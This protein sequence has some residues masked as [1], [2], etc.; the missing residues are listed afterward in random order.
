M[1]RLLYNIMLAL[2]WAAVTGRFTLGN[3]TLGFLIGY[4]VLYLT[5]DPSRAG[6]YVSRL[7]CALSLV[8]FF[9]WELFR[10]N[11]R[12][13]YELLTPTHRMK[14]AIVAIPLDARSDAQIL[15][16]TTLITL[17]PDSFAIYVSHD[18]RTLYVHSM[19][20]EDP[21]RYRRRIKDTYERRVLEVLA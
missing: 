13:T 17:T 11:M 21:E 15:L 1:S 12:V 5:R 10:A 2:A 8:A 7:P 20:V 16:L 19:Y 14:P 9:V 3:L 4:A 18:R 6:R